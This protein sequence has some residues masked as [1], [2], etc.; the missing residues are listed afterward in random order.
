[1]SGPTGKMLIKQ[2]QVVIS[3]QVGYSMMSVRAAGDLKSFQSSH[4]IFTTVP[5]Y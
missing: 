1:M 5:E 2:Q 3:K 4:N